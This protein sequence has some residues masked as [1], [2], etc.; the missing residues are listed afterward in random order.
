MKRELGGTK[1]MLKAVT[2]QT[3][4][5]WVLATIVYQ[6]GSRIETG[7]INL[8]NAIVIIIISITVITIILSKIKNKKTECTSCPYCNS[9]SKK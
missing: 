2:F 5:A 4:F 6:I 3:L 1:K 8:A 7:K 9:C